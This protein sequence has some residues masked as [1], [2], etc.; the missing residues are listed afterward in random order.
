MSSV[1]RKG[2][3]AAARANLEVLNGLARRRCSSD[4]SHKYRSAT[5]SIAARVGQIRSHADRS[6]CRSRAHRRIAP[7]EKLKFPPKRPWPGMNSSEDSLFLLGRSGKIGLS[8][9]LLL[10]DAGYRASAK[11]WEDNM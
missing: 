7:K 9:V 4:E 8:G 10:D 3:F 2:R 5:S 1:D 11:I 6:H